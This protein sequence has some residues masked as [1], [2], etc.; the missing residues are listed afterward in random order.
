MPLQHRALSSYF[1]LAET[2]MSARME[3]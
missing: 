3:Q 2:T 1:D